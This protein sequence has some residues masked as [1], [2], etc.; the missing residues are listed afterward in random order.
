M[1]PACS[2]AIEKN[3]NTKSDYALG[4]IQIR[5]ESVI[6]WSVL[7]AVEVF[8]R[9]IFSRIRNGFGHSA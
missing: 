4:P 1:R 7:V 2:R 3:A 8:L 6:I 9:I 5:S